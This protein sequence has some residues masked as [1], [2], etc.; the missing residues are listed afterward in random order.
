LAIP[1]TPIFGQ[2]EYRIEIAENSR[3]GASIFEFNSSLT[4]NDVIEI[5]AGNEDKA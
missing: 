4:S 1:E 3:I 2:K 5:V